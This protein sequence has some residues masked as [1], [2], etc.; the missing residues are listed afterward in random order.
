MSSNAGNTTKNQ[1]R[2]GVGT[3]N[4]VAFATA[5]VPSDLEKVGFEKIQEV[6]AK[7][8]E[9][10]R[11]VITQMESIVSLIQSTFDFMDKMGI[12]EM[13]GKKITEEDRKQFQ[14]LKNEYLKLKTEMENTEALLKK[15]G[16]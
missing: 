12:Q 7:S 1:S 14:N 2:S 13:E 8:L 10:A 6:V 16:E 11:A 4:V 5:R 3:S 15:G 9:A